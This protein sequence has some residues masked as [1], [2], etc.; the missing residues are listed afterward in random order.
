MYKNW[1]DLIKPKRLQ[2]EADTLTD[3]YGKFYA[4][5]FERGFGTTLGNSLRR[6]LLSSLQGAAISSVRIK[7]VLHE[8]S[9]IPGVTEDVTDVIL[10]LKGVLLK[11][12]GSDSRNVRIVKKGAGEITAADIITDSQV[13]ILNPDHHIATCSKEADVEIDMVVKLGKGYVP[14]ERNRDE[15]AP[16]GTIPIDSLFSPLRKVNFNVTNARVGQ[17]TDYDKLT[18]EVWSDGSVRPDD[19]VAYAAKILKEQLQIFINFDEEQEPEESEETEESR[20][21]NENLYRTVDE[22]ELSVRSA[23]CLKNA[24]IRL[25]GDLVQRSEAEMLKTQNFGRKSLNEIKDILAEMG[26]GLGMVLENFPDPEY[27]KILQ[28]QADEE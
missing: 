20:R 10:N 26:L 15:K 16:V 23:N 2:V 7:G 19:A 18:L 13:E 1:R 17:I 22:L 21:I 12:H 3:T 5:P 14:A 25:I 27:L 28:K 6:V 4:E 8:F 11:L 24:N 9:T